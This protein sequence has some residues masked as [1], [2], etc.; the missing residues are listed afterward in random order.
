VPTQA[1]LDLAADPKVA[2]LHTAR[3]CTLAGTNDAEVPIELSA[4]ARQIPVQVVPEGYHATPM[5]PKSV[6]ELIVIGNA[7][8]T[9]AAIEAIVDD[10]ESPVVNSWVVDSEN[11]LR[12]A[13][14]RCVM[15]CLPGISALANVTSFYAAPL[16]RPQLYVALTETATRNAW[17]GLPPGP[18]QRHTGKNVIIGIIDTGIMVQHGDFKNADGTTRILGAWD[19]SVAGGGPSGIAN[20]GL[21]YTQSQ[22]QIQANVVLPTTTTM[23]HDTIG[24]GTPMA[25]I[26]AGNGNDARAGS[27]RYKYAGVAPEADLVVVKTPQYASEANIFDAVNFIF[28]RATTLGKRCVVY[29]AHAS[30]NGAH[31]GSAGLDLSLSSLAGQDKIIVAPSGNYGM[32]FDDGYGFQTGPRVHARTVQPAVSATPIVDNVEFVSLP[33]GAAPM[34]EFIRIEGWF[35]GD[36][37]YSVTVSAWE[38]VAGVMTNLGGVT[39]ANATNQAGDVT[40][41]ANPSNYR[42]VNISVRNNTQTNPTQTKKKIEIYIH[43]PTGQINIPFRRYTVSVTRTGGAGTVGQIDWYTS[44]AIRSGRSNLYDTINW[45]YREEGSPPVSGIPAD[46]ELLDTETIASPATAN[47]VISAGS[48]VTAV[49]WPNA[50]GGTTNRTPSSPTSPEHVRNISYF[51]GQGPRLGVEDDDPRPDVVC[52]GEFVLAPYSHYQIPAATSGNRG[53]GGIHVA[54]GTYRGGGTSVAGAFLAGA[55]ALLFSKYG[56]LSVASARNL[57]RTLTVSD[58][59]TGATPNNQ[60]GYGKI[61]L[62]SL[63]S[64]AGV[65]PYLPP[66]GGTP[67]HELP[68]DDPPIVQNQNSPRRKYLDPDTGNVSNA[69]STS[70]N[71]SLSAAP[72]GDD[73]V[74]MR[75]FNDEGELVFEQDGLYRS[76][77][78]EAFTWDHRFTD[79]SPAPAGTY[80][81]R[82]TYGSTTDTFTT[83]ITE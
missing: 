68:I 52:P 59:Y 31:D 2:D 27:F 25:G 7:S 46:F 74:V 60:A 56:T 66:P 65:D 64:T 80:F 18:Y 48:Y 4:G 57:I 54:M 78:D 26:A 55:I 79:G 11:S 71:E 38:T 13:T 41:A 50:S 3:L 36:H 30:N 51:S 12:L 34:S 82:I 17:G 45:T 19:Q 29:I 37:Q 47:N 39:A 20:Y 33:V 10:G 28:A 72:A 32:T 16:V 75:V 62:Y 14:V 24:H 53:E 58:Q 9:E 83:E 73:E 67:G 22:I 61:N 23:L 6:V 44:D 77:K 1:L 43:N 5:N 15:G 70:F 76:D 8:L 40:H 42:T 63:G 21:E 35:T 81:V 69:T 49:T